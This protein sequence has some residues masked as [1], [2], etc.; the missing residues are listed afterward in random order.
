MA[1]NRIG[2]LKAR[3][4][5]LF[6]SV[7][8]ATVLASSAAPF[9]SHAQGTVRI[10]WLGHEFYRVTSPQGIVVVTSPWLLNYDGPV[11]LDELT[12]TDIILVPNAH[13]DDMGNPIE[14]A[15][16]SGATV[17]APGPLGRYLMDNGLDPSQS[18]RNN[19]SGGLLSRGDVTIKGGPSAH[20]NTLPNGA[21]GG[22]AASYFILT[23]DAPTVF[24]SGHATMVADLA[25]YAS[26]YQ[27]EVAILGLTEAP[28]FAQVARL[29][30]VQNPR[31][32][33]IIPSHIRPNDPILDEA[34]V[35]LDKVGLGNLLF[36]PELRQVYEF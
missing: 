33:A 10:E 25:I 17:V 18:F 28:E 13:N 7:L 36:M 20:D 14:V 3:V 26:V 32:R 4:A 23:R 29:M 16:V 12:R 15:A 9:I 1:R 6:A 22:P 11:L 5:V 27:P 30:S 24:F 31:L 34:R 35:E 21:D 8:V 19:I 2:I